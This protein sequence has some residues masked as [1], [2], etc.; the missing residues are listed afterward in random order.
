MMKKHFNKNL[1]M[2]AEENTNLKRVKYVG[3]VVIS[4]K[5]MIIKLEIT[6]ISLENI[7]DPV[8]GN[9]I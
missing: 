3:F 7:E 1:I 9:V 4:M 2:T 8:V 5:M 6:F